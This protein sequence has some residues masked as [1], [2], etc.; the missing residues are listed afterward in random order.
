MHRLESDLSGNQPKKAN[1]GLMIAVVVIIVGAALGAIFLTSRSSSSSS[2]SYDVIATVTV[3]GH[4]AGLPCAALRLPCALPT[5]IKANL[6]LYQSKYYYVSEIT[7]NNVVYTVWY[8]NSTY[9]CVSP[10]FQGTSTCPP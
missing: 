2:T 3:Y 6:T 9:Y 1:I 10:Q 7:A 5:S 8:D 4:A